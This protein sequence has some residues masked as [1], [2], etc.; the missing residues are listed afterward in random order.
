[1]NNIIPTSTS[2]IK[3]IGKIMPEMNNIFDGF[4]TRVPV[5][6][7][8][9]IEI[10]AQTTKKTN[11]KEINAAFAD[12]AKNSL[13][14]YLAYCDEPIVSSDINNS[15]YS[16]IFDALS[17]KVIGDDFIQIL[18]WYDNETGYAARLIDLIKYIS[19]F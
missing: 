2:A 3:T 1:M 19:K 5:A 13:K 4:A 14:D 12:Y 6:D 9:F 8:S 10:V 11:K 15:K 16:A 18:A 17:T 7:C